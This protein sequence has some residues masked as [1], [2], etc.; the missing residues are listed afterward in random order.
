MCT[1]CARVVVEYILK[2]NAI[3]VCTK[4]RGRTHLYVESKGHLGRKKTE[5]M[6]FL[7]S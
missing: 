5:K 4:I 7:M 3:H 2:M 6:S 1:S